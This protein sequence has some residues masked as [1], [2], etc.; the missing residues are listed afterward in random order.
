[1]MRLVTTKKTT[2]AAILCVCAFIH[3]SSAKELSEWNELLSGKTALEQIAVAQN[4]SQE[5]PPLPALH[6]IPVDG[7]R[8]E[9][10]KLALTLIRALNG[11]AKELAQA[12]EAKENIDNRLKLL[13][14]ISAMAEKKGGYLNELIQVSADNILILGFSFALE[15]DS[16]TAVALISENKA[17]PLHPKTWI[18]AHV[19][20]DPWLKKHQERIEA[21]SDDTHA[22]VAMNTVGEGHKYNIGNPPTV[23][24]M[25]NSANALSLWWRLY[26]NDYTLSAVLPAAVDYLEKGGE[27]SNDANEMRASVKAIY[28]EDGMPFTHPLKPRNI[29]AEALWRMRRLAIDKDRRERGLKMWFGE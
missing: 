11:E 8:A 14:G 2:L 23:E 9:A 22:F 29:S 19:E 20:A 21:L 25:V 5:W 16:E 17:K 7:G 10:K 3:E 12:A 13:S 28:G 15:N 24:K 1:M 6:Q 4:H 27:F 26:T 18:M